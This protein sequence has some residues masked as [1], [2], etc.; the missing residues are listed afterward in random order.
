LDT[1]AVRE[2]FL[3]CAELPLWYALSV[4]PKHEQR[5][6][7]FLKDQGI[8]P[9]APIRTERKYYSNGTKYDSIRPLFPRYIFARFPYSQRH[10]V[11][12]TSG[13]I[14]IIKF[15]P[16]PIAIP[17]QEIQS[18]RIMAASGAN[19]SPAPFKSG[20]KV[21]VKEGP[22]KGVWGTVVRVDGEDHLQVGIEMLGRAINVKFPVYH[23]GLAA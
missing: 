19:M 5:S 3:A 13:V 17:E 1:N 18:V 12:H 6:A 2:H 11:L 15:G 23:V 14:E 7:D 20:D 9:F 10:T 16:V 22:M 21:E 8:E 4:A